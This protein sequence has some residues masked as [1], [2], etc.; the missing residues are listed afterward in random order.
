MMDHGIPAQRPAIDPH[1]GLWEIPLGN[2]VAPP[3]SECERYGIP[4]GLRSA[5]AKRQDYFQAENG[6]ITGMDWNLWN[7]YAMTPAE[8][9]ATLKYTL[10]LHLN[11]NRSPMTVGF[12][13]ELYTIRRDGKTDPG[14]ILSR[15]AAVE[16]FLAYAL[17]KPE[18]R[19]VDHRELLAWLAH[20]VLLR[21]E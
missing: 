2:Y 9:L 15:R 5:L 1:P 14:I 8:F 3:D 17:S 21:R 11:G 12:H 7:E 18:V 6:E 16:A 10:D 13:S 20:P 19:L 4:P